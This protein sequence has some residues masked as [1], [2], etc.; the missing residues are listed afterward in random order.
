MDGDMATPRQLTAIA[1]AFGE[2]G[3]GSPERDV[4]L[5]VISGWVGTRIN[6][7]KDLMR[8]EASY[9]IDFLKGEAASGELAA[10]IT[11][12]RTATQ[13]ATQPATAGAR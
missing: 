9:I 5:A 13:A 7:M 4:R 12:A 8:V 6:T 11:T 1:A 2:H 10:T 3:V